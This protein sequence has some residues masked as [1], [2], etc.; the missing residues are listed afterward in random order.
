MTLVEQYTMSHR[1]IV[2]KKS[3]V[4]ESKN[5]SE[6]ETIYQLKESNDARTLKAI[7]RVKIKYDI[8]FIGRISEDRLT[9]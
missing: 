8:T 5:S 2:A 1:D 9:I 6:T 3:E 4:C 7:N